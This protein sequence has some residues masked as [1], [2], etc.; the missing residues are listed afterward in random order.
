MLGAPTV[1]PAAPFLESEL[2]IICLCH[3]YIG[4]VNKNAQVMILGINFQSLED[5]RCQRATKGRKCSIEA[6]M[7]ALVLWVWGDSICQNHLLSLQTKQE[8]PKSKLSPSEDKHFWSI[9]SYW[10][11]GFLYPETSKRF[12]GRLKFTSW[13]LVF[14][15]SS[16]L[17]SLRLFWSLF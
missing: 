8:S 16:F 5:E 4:I 7:K 10:N 15:D 13:T 3:W 11:W 2:E 1:G 14:H 12:L 6:L 17:I 9:D